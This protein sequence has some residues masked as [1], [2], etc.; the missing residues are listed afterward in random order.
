[1]LDLRDYNPVVGASSSSWSPDE[2]IRFTYDQVRIVM[3]WPIEEI[4]DDV[5]EV[6]PAFRNEQSIGYGLFASCDMRAGA[7]VTCFGAGDMMKY[8]DWSEYAASCGIP[9]EW[10]GIQAE[11]CLPPPT[12]A[13]AKVM[14]YDASWI[15]NY[16]D[17]R[18]KWSYMNHSSTPNVEMVVPRSG[19]VVSW[20]ALT[21]IASGSELCFAYGGETNDYIEQASKESVPHA[22]GKRTR[23]HASSLD[24]CFSE[25][26]YGPYKHWEYD[27]E[28]IQL[29][30]AY[31]ARHKAHLQRMVEYSSNNRGARHEWQGV[32][33][34][35]PP[36]RKLRSLLLCMEHARRKLHARKL[37]LLRRFQCGWNAVTVLLSCG[38]AS[39]LVRD[40]DLHVGP[41]TRRSAKII[42]REALKHILT[43]MSATLSAMMAVS[44]GLQTQGAACTVFTM[45]P[46]SLL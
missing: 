41:I 17:K 1:M 21:D 2:T 28:D 18:P 5:T 38:L 33:D 19:C 12:K 43:V 22:N 34:N 44:H 9:E 45:H 13:F 23:C 40:G 39:V 3:R 32:T 16:H 15:D 11:R 20:T 6:K 42:S 10:G 36:L 29:A 4:S 24:S 30:L 26:L 8:R 25:A 46:C 35:R 14:F 27:D 31:E 7:R 37:E